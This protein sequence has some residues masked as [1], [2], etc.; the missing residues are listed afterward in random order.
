MITIIITDS[1]GN[2]LLDTK[3]EDN[4]FS[5]LFDAWNKTTF[6]EISTRKARKIVFKVL[7]KWITN[8]LMP[9]KK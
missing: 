1:D 8:S 5:I 2:K 7:D 9:V 6:D 4:D 3:G